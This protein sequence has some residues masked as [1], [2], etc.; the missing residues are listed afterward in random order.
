MFDPSVT[1]LMRTVR[2]VFVLLSLVVFLYLFFSQVRVHAQAGVS[3]S[4]ADFNERLSPGEIRNLSIKVRNRSA[5]NE[6]YYL[7]VQNISGVRDGGVP[8][9]APDRAE[10]TGYEIADWITLATSS[11]A[12]L[13]G[14]EAVVDFSLRVPDNATPGSHFGSVFFSTEA[15]EIQSSGAAVGFQVA[16]IIHVRVAGDV[17]EAA[18][19]RQFSTDQ[20]IYGSSNVAFTA[21]I[22]NAGNVLVT[23]I[24]SVEVKN[25]F[26]KKVV[27]LPF[28][29]DSKSAVFPL[30]TRDFELS[31]EDEGPGF[32]RY[33][34]TV[35]A[36]YGDSGARFTLS[37]TVTFWI[38][39]M[40]IIGPA[41]G[42]LAVVL[43]VTFLIAR[44][45]ISRTLAQYAQ[46][47]SSRRLVQRR[48]QGSSVTMLVVLVMLVVT[49]LF[50]IV[51]L[52]LFA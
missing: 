9:F 23:P 5:E 17:I 19:V 25:M 2:F 30:T 1:I 48:R 10:V 31:W 33:E 37:S 34:A 44:L 45:Y 24:G 27:S 3:I 4:P 20:Y 11:V 52:A 49:A 47:S 16:N 36:A 51:L 13:A 29:Q 12:I 26:G 39:P 43:L 28:N 40:N 22:E 32:G 35:S 41:L 21:R 50:L 18:N 8:I 38:L 6:V 42:I 46:S 14:D 7:S 15:P